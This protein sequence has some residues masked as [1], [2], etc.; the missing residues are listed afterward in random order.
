MDNWCRVCIQDAKGNLIPI[1]YEVENISIANLITACSGVLIK[2]SDHLPKNCCERCVEG[3]HIAY[4]IVKQCQDSDEK[5]KKMKTNQGDAEEDFGGKDTIETHHQETEDESAPDE[6][7]NENETIQNVSESTVLTTCC[8]CR[9]DFETAD[10]L[11][12]HIKKLHEPEKTNDDSKKPYQCDICFKRYFKK[13]SLNRHKRMGISAIGVHLQEEEQPTD[14]RCCGC[15]KDFDRLELLKEH[16]LMEHGSNKTSDETKP[17]QCEICFKRYSNKTSLARHFRERFA[18]RSIRTVRKLIPNQCCGCREKFSTKEQLRQHSKYVHEPDRV[19]N[20]GGLKPFE[21]S[22]CYSRYSTLEAFNRHKSGHSNDQLYQCQQC[23]KSFVKR[24]MLRYHERKHHNGIQ[25]EVIGP[26]QCTRCGKTFMQPSSL[27]NHEKVHD[28][29]ERYECSIC[30]KEFF[31]KG[32]LQTHLKLHSNPVELREAL[33]ECSVCRIGFKTPN[34]LEVHS[35]VHTG[36]KPYTCKYCSKQFAHAS[37]HK[38]HLLTH[39][40]VK[41]FV[42]RFCGREFS[43]RPNMLIHEKSHGTERNARCDIC[44][45]DFV[46]DRYLRK[47]RRRHFS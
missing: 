24:I 22:V 13:T 36:E 31:S 15:R 28:R 12:D 1:S 19:T 37:G 33:Y 47:H 17:F 14:H 2:E 45:K 26:Y 8:A 21:C 9:A 5:L 23:D 46:H 43:N 11:A 10:A 44:S 18:D 39:S 4:S 34:Y 20:L 29:S 16:S 35:R 25:R 40:G 30:Q 27:T 7:N 6:S 38:R 3:L 42:C 41:P 32:N